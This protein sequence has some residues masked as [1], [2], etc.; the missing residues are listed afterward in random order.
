MVDNEAAARR[1]IEHLAAL[2]HPVLGDAQH[3]GDVAR[4]FRPR[5]P[6]LALH[7][8]H[9]GLRHPITDAPLAWDSPLPDDLATWSQRLTAEPPP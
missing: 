2:G 6:R 1:V 7:A 5:P 4:Q 8:A 9:L 3:G